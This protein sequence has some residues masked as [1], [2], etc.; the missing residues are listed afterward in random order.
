MRINKYLARAGYATR[1]GADDLIT[2]GRV[3]VN[4]KKAK[5]GDQIT[6]T[7][8][9]VVKGDIQSRHKYFALYKPKGLLTHS[10]DPEKQEVRD[11]APKG[12]FPVGRLDKH[13]EGL[14]I[15]TTDGRVTD[16]L[17]NPQYDHEKE[18]EVSVREPISARFISQLER[19]VNI[20]G[21]KTKPAK[22]KQL[23]NQKF[24]LII[25]EGKK[26]QIR[27]MCMALGNPVTALKRVR[28]MN[29]RLG[30][31]KPGEARPILGEEQKTFLQ[32][33]GLR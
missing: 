28:V 25:T 24:R 29:I 23:G 6:A 15:V 30:D 32:T 27:R 11:I 12:T 31:T 22:A 14:L 8:T 17:L 20:E 21:Y 19:G 33:L 2:S 9:V 13:S 1:R 7:D 16:R 10:A 5:L 3:L 18:Y 4:G 26:H